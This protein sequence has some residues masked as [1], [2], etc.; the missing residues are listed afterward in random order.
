MPTIEP[1][2]KGKKKISTGLNFT[3]GIDIAST[4]AQSFFDWKA[5]NW[6]GVAVHIY[7]QNPSPP[8]PPPPKKKKKI[9]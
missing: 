6:P 9:K 5:A 4:L 2:R 8:P 7:G 1:N 3:R